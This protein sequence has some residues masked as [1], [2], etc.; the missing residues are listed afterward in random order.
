[1]AE[2]MDLLIQVMRL[3]LQLVQGFVLSGQSTEELVF[4]G[5]Q[6][7][8]SESAGLFGLFHRTE[9]AGH[10]GVAFLLGLH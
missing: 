4:T 1:M 10:C 3:L 5:I 2:V 9:R 6:Q 8:L 7:V